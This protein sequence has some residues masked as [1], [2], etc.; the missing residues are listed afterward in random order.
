[1]LSDNF[2]NSYFV[3]NN[4]THCV[5][6]RCHGWLAMI[7]YNLVWLAAYCIHIDQSSSNPTRVHYPQPLLSCPRV[8]QMRK[9]LINFYKI[10]IFSIVFNKKSFSKFFLFDEYFCTCSWFTSVRL[11]SGQLQFEP[12]TI[13]TNRSRINLVLTEKVYLYTS[14][15]TKLTRLLVEWIIMFSLCWL[16]Y[17]VRTAVSTFLNQ[18]LYPFPWSLRFI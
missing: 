8:C 1:M 7:V 16:S 15:Y 14:F 4:T 3:S 6:V 12:F 13:T 5:F 2:I 9:N 17:S 11:S 18:A 10:L